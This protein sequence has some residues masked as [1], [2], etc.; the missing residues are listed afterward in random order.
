MFIDLLIEDS[1]A[2]LE[3]HTVGCKQCKELPDSYKGN[4]R[5]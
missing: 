2:F 1:K 3:L 4:V 5:A